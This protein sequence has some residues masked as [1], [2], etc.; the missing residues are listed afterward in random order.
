MISYQQRLET[1]QRSFGNLF[2]LMGKEIEDLGFQ[3]ALIYL[4]Q[5][6][7]AKLEELHLL[8]EELVVV[9]LHL[10]LKQ[11]PNWLTRSFSKVAL[12]F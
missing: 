8:S 12:Y 6:L 1:D 5:L 3:E 11:T 2:F 7:M 4:L 10:F 9:L